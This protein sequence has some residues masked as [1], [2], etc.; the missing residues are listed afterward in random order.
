MNPDWDAAACDYFV[1]DPNERHL[2]RK[3]GKDCPIA[4]GV[5]FRKDALMDIGLYDPAMRLAEDE[6]SS[7]VRFAKKHHIGHIALPLYR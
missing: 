5:L 3:S 7:R 4:C 1:V 2:E 6:E